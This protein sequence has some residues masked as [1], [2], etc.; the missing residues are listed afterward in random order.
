MGEPLKKVYTKDYVCRVADALRDAGL[1]VTN[2][3]FCDFIFQKDWEELEL[4]ART[5]RLR[6]GL[7][8]FLPSDYIKSLVPLVKAAKNFG[9]YEGMFFPEY[10][11]KYGL[12]YP[13]ESFSVLEKLTQYSSAEF[14]I[15]P[16][17]ENY[18]REGEKQMLLWS[19]HNNHHVRRLSS[20]G[21]RPLLPWASQLKT[22]RENP[23]PI[24]EILENLNEDESL[25]VRKSV[26]NNL[27]DISKDHPELALKIAKRWVKNKK[28]H[29]IWIVK[30][31]LRTLLK[32]GDSQAMTL[33][34]YS[35][36]KA[37]SLTDFEMKPHCVFMEES[38]EFSFKFK[39]SNAGKFRFEYALHFLKKNGT[40]TK[41]VFKISEKEL[42]KGTHSLTKSHAF[43]KIST[44]KYYDGLHF[45][46]VIINGVSFYKKGFFLWDKKPS[47]FTYILLTEKGT[48]YT[49]VTTDI[50][51]RFSEHQTSKKG[52][53]YTKQN[54]PV[55]ILH[56]EAAS[57][58]SEA[59]K[60]ES[61]IKKLTRAQKEELIHKLQ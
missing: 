54:K 23:D 7:K 16:F 5:S 51:R 10:V 55:E 58:R 61:Q 13:S 37:I 30:H 60:R 28:P 38:L 2:K 53:K 33:F 1:K 39:T 25:Y 45:L 44:R 6:E 26:A 43:K 19:K 15:R 52:A 47:Y 46:E 31:G 56:L 12:D 35:N 41:K 50:E 20:E 9:G 34:D 42:E 22:Y 8:E 29:T 4:K 36:P 24:V 17:L 27:N 59:Q 32:K 40:Y 14:A 18:P 11:E 49:G 3:K 57:N 21:I 48:F